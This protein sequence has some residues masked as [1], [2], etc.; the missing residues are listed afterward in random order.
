METLKKMI[1][2]TIKSGIAAY[3]V[4]EDLKR[5]L[6]CLDVDWA[7]LLC[8]SGRLGG[9]EQLTSTIRPLRLQESFQLYPTVYQIKWGLTIGIDRIDLGTSL[10]QKGCSL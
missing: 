10:D 3:Y 8:S 9:R 1:K 7:R 4:Q 6:R 5:S 2:N